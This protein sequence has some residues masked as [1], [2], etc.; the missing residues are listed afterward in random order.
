MFYLSLLCSHFWSSRNKREPLENKK[1]AKNGS[2][3]DQ[4]F[5][6]SKLFA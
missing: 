4:F 3:G 5:L 2:E 1:S 6:P